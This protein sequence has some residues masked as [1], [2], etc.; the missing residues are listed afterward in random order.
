MKATTKTKTIQFP[1][2]PVTW[3]W[4]TNKTHE[5]GWGRQTKRTNRG[6][7]KTYEQ[8]VFTDRRTQTQFCWLGCGVGTIFTENIVKQVARFTKSK[9]NFIGPSNTVVFSF[10]QTSFLTT[11]SNTSLAAKGAP[12]TPHRLQNPKWPPGGPKM[13]DGSG[14]V[15][16]PRIRAI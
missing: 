13:A 6:A 16:T 11:F 7:N 5:Q 2:A 1:S 3:G 14:K 10:L 15:S 9:Q 8:K 12:A 4:G